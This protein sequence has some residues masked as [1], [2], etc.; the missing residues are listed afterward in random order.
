MDIE[1]EVLLQRLKEHDA[2]C[3]LSLSKVVQ[4]VTRAAALKRDIMQ[5]QPLS[6]PVDQ[7]PNHLPPSVSHFLAD[8]LGIPPDYMEGCWTIFKD[9]VWDYPSAEETKH[10][11]M[12]AFKV[13]GRK[14]GL[15]TYTLS[16]RV[17]YLMFG[18]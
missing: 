6:V 3:F 18:R 14:R 9:L 12:D 5:P 15:S 11:D 13:H 17:S 4:F 1:L 2:L 7:A 16:L 8:S 10:A